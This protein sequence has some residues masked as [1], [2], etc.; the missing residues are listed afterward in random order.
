MSKINQNHFYGL[1]FI[2]HR[3]KLTRFKNLLCL[4]LDFFWFVHFVC[5]FNDAK[6]QIKKKFFLRDENS[7]KGLCGL[8]LN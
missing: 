7:P 8:L 2:S 4:R 6:Y 1:C 5:F 3:T